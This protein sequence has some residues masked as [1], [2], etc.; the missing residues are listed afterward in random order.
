MGLATPFGRPSRAQHAGPFLQGAPQS[1][2]AG[3]QMLEAPIQHP[4]DRALCGA[5]IACA[6]TL[7]RALSALLLKRR[8]LHQRVGTSSLRLPSSLP[9]PLLLLACPKQKAAD[10][11]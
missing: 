7:I 8:C 4:L 6:E 11:S 3:C 2:R 9:P 5:E 10:A 1:L